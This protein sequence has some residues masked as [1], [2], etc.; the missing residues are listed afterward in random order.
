MPSVSEILPDI[1]RSIV[2]PE[3]T[4]KQWNPFFG[5]TRNQFEKDLD[6]HLKS[7]K[8]FV[9][10]RLDEIE[11]AAKASGCKAAPTNL[12][13]DRYR[14]AVRYQVAGIEVSEFRERFGLHADLRGTRLAIRGILDE[15]GL[16]RRP[17]KNI[18][19]RKKRK[20]PS[21]E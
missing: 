13:P 5:G 7:V 20:V 21:Q 8:D 3:F 4:R 11:N 15:V 17:P 6:A 1:D 19:R 14:W 2:P 16:T 18:G 10:R 9:I 12:D